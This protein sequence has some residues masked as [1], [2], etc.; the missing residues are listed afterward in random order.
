VQ[1]V[2]AASQKGGAGKTSLVRN[3]AVAANT[4]R[5]PAAILDT[6]PQGTLTSWWNRRE[7]E[8]PYLVSGGSAAEIRDTLDRLRASGVGSVWIDTP[9]SVHGWIGELVALADLA[10]IPVRPTPDDLD[11]VGQTIDLVDAAGVAFAFVISQ[12]KPRTRLAADAYPALAQHGKVAPAALHDR[13]DYASAALRGLGVTE[14]APRS[15]AAEEIG[16]LLKYVRKQ[17]ARGR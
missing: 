2:I 6:D 13:V 1:V 5:Q 16:Q 15:S 9:P 7:P 12:A 3:L 4:A 8:T 14:H 17:L 10:L 11:A